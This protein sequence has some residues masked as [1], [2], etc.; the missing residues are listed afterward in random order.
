MAGNPGEAC[1]LALSRLEQ[2]QRYDLPVRR[3]NR[4][5]L[6]AASEPSPMRL[7]GGTPPANES[8]LRSLN[9]P[10]PLAWTLVGGTRFRC[11]D[12]SFVLILSCISRQRSA[13]A[14]RLSVFTDTTIEICH[15]FA[16]KRSPNQ[17]P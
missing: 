16:A 10:L 5:V 6:G 2:S 15:E 3:Q 14:S 17:S 7:G 9:F 4:R 8:K 12:A 11:Y 1:F 13:G